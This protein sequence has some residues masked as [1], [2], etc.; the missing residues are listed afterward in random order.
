MTK[1]KK[2]LTFRK[3]QIRI[4]IVQKTNEYSFVIRIVT[5]WRHYLNSF[6]VL[7]SGIFLFHRKK[8]AGRLES[9][10]EDL[11]LVLKNRKNK[12][13]RI[14]PNTNKNGWYFTVNLFDHNGKR[15]T[16]RIHRLVAKAFIG[17]IPICQL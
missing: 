8:P 16:E 13:G 10:P 5:L 14:M 2:N 3:T 4:N 1:S 7:F 6:H 12:N 9:L 11:A 17:E 15:R